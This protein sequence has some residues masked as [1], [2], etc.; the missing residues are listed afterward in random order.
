MG[1]ILIL[2]GTLIL[3][4]SVLVLLIAASD[5]DASTSSLWILGAAVVVFL[6]ATYLIDLGRSLRRLRAV[7]VLASD[8]RPPVLYLRS[9]KADARGQPQAVPG[10][11]PTFLVQ[12]SRKSFEEKLAR[13][14]DSIGPFIA[15]GDPKESV[16]PS[17][18][19]RLYLSNEE[20][21]E[22]V[23]ELL[24]RAGFIV[25]QAG[26]SEGLVWELDTIL[27]KCDPTKL[28]IAL[29]AGSS[30]RTIDCAEYNRFRN[31]TA[32]LFRDPLPNISKDSRFMYFDNNWRPLL[33]RTDKKL[34]DMPIPQ[35]GS[36]G[37]Q[38]SVLACLQKRFAGKVALEGK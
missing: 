38:Q 1:G 26:D 13:T 8:R 15:I 25:I 18:A 22:R 2:V 31:V 28:L 9:F 36:P 20:W 24:D 17:G 6:L 3:I 5:S 7:D 23:T 32:H 12:L 10:A 30:D 16:P 33:L 27:K 34:A 29:P 14:L 11:L 21:Q 19:A 4:C 37:I 35:T